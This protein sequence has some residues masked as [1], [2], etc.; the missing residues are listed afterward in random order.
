MPRGAWDSHTVAPT[1]GPAA[2][3]LPQVGEWHGAH[4]LVSVLD[5]GGAFV[6]IEHSD[7]LVHAAGTQGEALLLGDDRSHR[8]EKTS[9]K[10]P[11]FLILVVVK[12]A[13]RSLVRGA[14]ALDTG[15]YERRRSK[16]G[17][18]PVSAC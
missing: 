4:F 11:F 15:E 8:Y 5:A 12:V 6:D 1:L 18:E 9:K 10:R 7:S 17:H 3:L 2:A 13:L 14:V 16:G